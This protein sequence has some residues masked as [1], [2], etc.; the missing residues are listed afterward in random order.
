VLIDFA[1]DLAHGTLTAR[2]FGTDPR[3]RVV[4][5]GPFQTY[6]PNGIVDAI[7]YRTVYDAGGKVLLDAHFNSHYIPVTAR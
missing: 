5:R 3:Y 1:E 4:V 7:F 6:H 2:F